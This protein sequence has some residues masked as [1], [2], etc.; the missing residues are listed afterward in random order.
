MAVSADLTRVSMVRETTPGATP[1]TPTFLV[2]RI[3]SEGVSYNPTTQLSNELNP[4]RQVAD[5]IVSGGSSGGNLGFELSRNA[6]FEEM[7]SAAFGNDWGATAPDRLEVGAILK[8]YTVEKDFMVQVEPAEVHDFHRIVR[9]IVD[10]LSLTFTPA[11]ADTGTIALLGG[12]YTRAGAP[13]AGATYT[14][15]GTR[16]VMVGA[17]AMPVVFEIGG[18]QYLAWCLSQVVLN[19]KNNGRAIECLGTLG[20]AEM[21]LGRFE[22][23]ITMQVYVGTDTT[24]IMDAFLDMAEI[25]F[26]MEA[27]DHFS[28]SYWFE[29]D[30][31]RIQTC[32]E[33]AGGTNQDVVLAV[34][35]QALVGATATPPLPSVES[36]VFVLRA[37]AVPLD[38]A[39]GGLAA[40]GGGRQAISTSLWSKM[41]ELLPE[42]LKAR[43]AAVRDMIQSGQ[44]DTTADAA[45]APAEELTI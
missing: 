45:A 13:I 17:D 33:V 24:V 41:K 37:P 30:R 1:A 14:P 27:L 39:T 16:P 21:V 12:T 5:V 22:C 31:C 34:T 15:A 2:A 4:A 9:A 36:C 7:L 8:T 28:N 25:A 20:A 32:T 11:A 3:T 18:V 44:A 40:A 38:T 6:W 42:D 35:L 43:Q 23:D 26:G 19:F 10:T 29:F